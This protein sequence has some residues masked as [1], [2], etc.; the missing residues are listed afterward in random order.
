V[1][2][3]EITEIIVTK[4]MGRECFCREEDKFFFDEFG[5]EFSPLT[6]DADW[7]MVYDNATFKG[8]VTLEDVAEWYH[9]RGE[10]KRRRSL[11]LIVKKLDCVG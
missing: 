5:L 6:S 4:V 10:S 11:E 7:A 3:K 8:L 9:M 1:S 2:D